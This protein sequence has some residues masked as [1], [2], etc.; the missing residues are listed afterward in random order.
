LKAV[1]KGGRREVKGQG[2]VMEEGIDQSTVYP[3]QGHIEKPL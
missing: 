3:Q 1:E 2:R